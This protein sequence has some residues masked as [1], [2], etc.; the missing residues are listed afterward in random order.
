MSWFLL[1]V[2]FNLMVAIC[3]VRVGGDGYDDGGD[4]DDDNGD[5][6]GGMVR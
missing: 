2:D 3:C 4:S 5:G 1:T 6:A